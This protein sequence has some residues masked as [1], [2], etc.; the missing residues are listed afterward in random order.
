[1]DGDDGWSP[2][3]PGLATDHLYETCPARLRTLPALRE[4]G[5]HRP[6]LG[7]VDPEDGDVCG[8]CLRVWRAR[9]PKAVT[10]TT[11]GAQR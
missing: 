2:W 9:R 7:S 1:V 10:A 6:G 4:S 11:G 5:W 3:W 8:W